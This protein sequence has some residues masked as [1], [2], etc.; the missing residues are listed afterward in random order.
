M[1]RLRWVF[2]IT[3]ALGLVVAGTV[4]VYVR[5]SATRADEI[6]A[7]IKEAIASKNDPQKAQALMARASELIAQLPPDTDFKLLL[8]D[9][10]AGKDS[11]DHLMQPTT[12]KPEEE[13]KPLSGHLVLVE[14]YLASS[15][16]VTVIADNNKA[17]ILPMP[18]TDKVLQEQSVLRDG[19]SV[20]RVGRGPQDRW[21]KYFASPDEKYVALED[22]V[23]GKPMEVLAVDSGKT[24]VVQSPEIEGHYGVDPFSFLQWEKDSQSFDVEVT[25]TYVKGPGQSLAYREVWQVRADSGKATRLKRQEQPWG[26]KLKW[27]D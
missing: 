3:V 22:H 18:M 13:K 10:D 17:A 4:F 15:Y 26:E 2:V 19:I 5:R 8:M 12:S 16:P 20:F 14:R 24:I 11:M 6:R 7:L 9:I 23:H 21:R 25:G 1:K 27:E